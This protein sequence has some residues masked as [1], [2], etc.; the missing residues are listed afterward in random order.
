MRVICHVCGESYLA[1]SNHHCP[2]C[3]SLDDDNYDD[4][5]DD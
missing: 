4:D 5:D 3:G 2:E 1:R